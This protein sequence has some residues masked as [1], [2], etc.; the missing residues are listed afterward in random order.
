[1]EPPG[2]PRRAT[3]RE[4]AQPPCPCGP[5]RVRAHRTPSTSYGRPAPG[6][7][8][9]AP[10]HENDATP[11]LSQPSAGLAG[12]RPDISTGWYATNT[13]Q[14]APEAGTPGWKPHSNA[15]NRA[16]QPK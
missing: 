2:R 4:P 11:R 1:M 8:S 15:T 5:P 16:T 13:G 10:S 12:A 14:P 3:R 6:K 7:V 9:A